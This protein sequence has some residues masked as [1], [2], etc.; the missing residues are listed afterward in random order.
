[1]TAYEYW[2]QSQ[3]SWYTGVRKVDRNQA[4][5]SHHYDP[6]VQHQEMFSQSN[7]FWSN[8]YNAWMFLAAGDYQ[9]KTI[10]VMTA[11]A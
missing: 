8:Y 6:A 3:Q 4:I 5:F 7:A 1:M 2:D 10:A 11:E 9:G